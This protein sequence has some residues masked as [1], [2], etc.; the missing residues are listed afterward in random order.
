[1]LVGQHAEGDDGVGHLALD[2]EMLLQGLDRRLERD[3]G[4]VGR[5][6]QDQRGLQGD[7]RPPRGHA[8]DGGEDAD[9]KGENDQPRDPESADVGGQGD[10]QLGVGLGHVVGDDREEADRQRDQHPV[11]HRGEGFVERVQHAQCLV[12]AR[13][14]DHAERQPD[15]RA[16][17]D[18]RDELALAQGLEDVGRRQ[19]ADEGEQA[20]L[21]AALSRAGHPAA[22]RRRGFVAQRAARLQNEG[23]QNGHDHGDQEAKAVDHAHA[24]EQRAGARLAQ[25]LP[26]A[27][28]QGADQN[29]QQ[30][31]RQQ[32]DVDVG[33][34]LQ[35]VGE[36]L[37]VEAGG[38]AEQNAG[39]DGLGI[40]QDPEDER[41]K[42]HDSDSA[43]SDAPRC[44]ALD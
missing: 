5:E 37:E 11:E 4:V 44:A 8:A 17:E 38:E 31:H 35:G 20:A 36:V 25:H 40:L 10:Q 41:A 34:R 9:V 21:S 2:L 15:Q 22:E 16:E 18:D 12:G 13:R 27:P 29:R 43:P 7:Q 28:D 42:L 24:A 32:R 3:E 26:D 30:A 23:D 6:G 14:A 33:D 1:M 19:G 39:D